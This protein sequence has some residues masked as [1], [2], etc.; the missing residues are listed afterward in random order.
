MHHNSEAIGL[1]PIF[2]ERVLQEGGGVA[3]ND[4]LFKARAAVK[5]TFRYHP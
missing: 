2:A 4:R 5:G 3:M 1:A